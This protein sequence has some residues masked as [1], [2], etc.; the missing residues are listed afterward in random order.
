MLIAIP[1]LY[2][3]LLLGVSVYYWNRFKKLGANKTFNFR[4]TDIWAAMAAL[5]PTITTV[6]IIL[7]ENEVRG[8]QSGDAYGM[9]VLLIFLGVSQI[10]GLFLGRIHIELPPNRGAQSAWESAVSIFTGGWI[11][12]LMPMIFPIL[13]LILIGSS[14]YYFD[15]WGTKLPPEPEE[16]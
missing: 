16:R 1:I 5:A 9:A 6:S 15:K 12:I 11:G 4:I 3:S 8:W 14:L 13:P 10:V 2:L 7:K